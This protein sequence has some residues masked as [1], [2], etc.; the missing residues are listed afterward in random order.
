MSGKSTGLGGSVAP[1]KRLKGGLV[2]S[3]FRNMIRSP[4][5]ISI[6]AI[7]ICLTKALVDGLWIWMVPAL[8]YV[9]V[10]FKRT[11]FEVLLLNH[12]VG[13]SITGRWEWYSKITPNIYLGSMPMDAY[14]HANVFTKDLGITSILS[15]VQDFEIVAGTL[16]GS[17]VSADMW[18]KLDVNHLHLRSEDFQSPSFELLHEGADWIKSVVDSKGKVYVHCKSGIGRS[19]SLVIAYFIKYHGLSALDAWTRVKTIRP[20][21]LSKK[22]R[23]FANIVNFEVELKATNATARSEAL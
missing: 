20:R 22:S 9:V 4:L 6:V 12:V 19:A 14:D 5:F 3:V 15:I 17:P 21:V 11:L 1:R 2:M 16:I 10:T 23:Q 8:V 13:Y 7:T 18:K